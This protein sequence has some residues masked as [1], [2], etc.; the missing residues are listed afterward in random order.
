VKRLL[1]TL[2]LLGGVTFWLFFSYAPESIRPFEPIVLRAAWIGPLWQRLAVATLFLFLVV[3]MIIAGSTLRLGAQAAQT[4]MGGPLR[5][6]MV[7]EI[8]WTLLPIL[9]TIGLAAISSRTWASLT[10]V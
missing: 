2:F 5:L 8:F 4:G 6:P 10:A 3:Q 7:A 9:M 1:W